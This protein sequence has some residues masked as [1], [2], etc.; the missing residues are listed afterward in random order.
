LKKHSVYN[1]ADFSWPSRGNVLFGV[2]AAMHFSGCTASPSESVGAGRIVN[3]TNCQLPGDQGRGS[4]QGTWDNPPVPIVFDKDFYVT[5]E[6]ETI[7]SLKGAVET[8]NRWSRLKGRQVLNIIEDGSGQNGGRDIPELTDC[9]Q[10][11]YTSS[12]RDAVGIWKIGT[13]GPR[14]NART[15][16][17]NQEK[18]LPDGVQG[19]TDWTVQGGKITGASILLNFE[20][21]N[22]P[23]K[24]LID[25]ESLLLHELGH[26]LG[27]LHS[28]NGSG[29][30]AIDGTSAPV[31]GLAPQGYIDA[32][33]FPFLQVAQ[34]RRDLKQND[35][36]R[37]NCL[38]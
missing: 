8:W 7:P 13:N 38:Y 20:G 9:V 23:G 32:V 36:D 33:M 22:A 27:L 3:F 37:V 31:C 21:F 17:L 25:V 4:F 19:Q 28:C 18:I 14:K 15:S 5:D 34:E 35:Y 10:A 6:G 16:C 2:L 11:S 30:G 12:T 24:Q 29:G 1:F 26:V